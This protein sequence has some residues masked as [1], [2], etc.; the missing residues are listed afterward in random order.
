MTSKNDLLCQ[1]CVCKKFRI[2]ENNWGIIPNEQISSEML[3]TT[4][5]CTECYQEALTELLADEIRDKKYLEL[6]VN[7]ANSLCSEISN[8]KLND[9][10]FSAEI[11]EDNDGF[12][13]IFGS[14]GNDVRL[15]LRIYYGVIVF[16]LYLSDGTVYCDNAKPKDKSREILDFVMRKFQAKGE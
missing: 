10:K 2:D 1:C 15:G 3:I 4:G 7:N 6:L 13:L 12:L 14:D 8:L 16:Y 5:Y 9:Q 11:C